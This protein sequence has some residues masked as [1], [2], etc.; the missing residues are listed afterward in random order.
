[1]TEITQPENTEE[2]KTEP[3]IGEF[4]PK[5]KFLNFISGVNGSK[6]RF[7]RDIAFV[8]GSKLSGILDN[9]V[10]K[11][12]IC[13]E[14]TIN[15]EEVDTKLTD[16]AMRQ[17]LIT[18]IDEMDVTG[19]TQKFVV[20]GLEFADK[21]GGR[22]YLEVE[23]KKPIDKLKALFETEEEAKVSDKGLSILDQLFGSSEST[24]EVEEEKLA[25]VLFTSETPE[26]LLR[27]FE[28][29]NDEVI[30]PVKELSYMEQQ[31][32]KMKEDKINE[33]K[34]RIEDKQKDIQKAKMDIR[35]AEGKLKESTEALGIL[36]TRL[37]SMFD[38]EK[39]NGYVFNVSEEQK[40]ETGL[41]ES[42]KDV[43]DKIADLMGLKKDV[44]FDHLTGGFYK[45]RIAKKEDI[46]NQDFKLDGDVYES[47]L[48]IDLNGKIEIVDGE[49]QYRGKLNWHQL[50]G[51][52]IRNGFEQD[53]E[54]D[55]LCLSN[56]Y[57]SKEEDKSKEHI[58]T[59]GC[60]HD[61]IEDSE[62]DEDSEAGIEIENTFEEEN[63]YPIGEEFYFSIYHEPTASNDLGDAE[64]CVLINPKSYW[65]KE[66]HQ[67]DQHI[68]NLLKSKFPFIKSLGEKFEE[69]EEGTFTISNFDGS[70]LMTSKH[71]NLVDTIELMCKSGIKFDKDFQDFISQKDSQN[72]INIITQLGYQNIIC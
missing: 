56:S 19:Y 24:D 1:M 2:V 71:T 4:K 17:R 33:L 30:E 28:G 51:K 34:F 58:C 8:K 31:F 46:T 67:Y 61:S 21:D 49:F 6:I 47:I 39:A 15:F 41:D 54:F 68:E 53:P 14:G 29:E 25:Q 11:I 32:L 50:V 18:E 9:V 48:S 44:L 5:R 57:E 16:K 23:N 63:G 52:M 27:E 13:D 55:K 7:I 40:M 26:E 69:A 3:I 36:E 43:A 65:D 70:N 12:T 10:F 42:T 20:A 60:S 64:A 37:E 62:E 22:C 45:I 35:Q 66:G 59:D 72:V 38:G